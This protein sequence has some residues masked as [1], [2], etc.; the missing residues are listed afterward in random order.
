MS[1]QLDIYSHEGERFFVADQVMG[2]L[3]FSAAHFADVLKLVSIPNKVSFLNFQGERRPE[4]RWTASLVSEGGVREL[5]ARAKGASSG[6]LAEFGK[7]GFQ[8]PEK[9]R[10]LQ[11]CLEERPRQLTRYFQPQE[12]DGS[13]DEA[14]FVGYEIT[15]LLGYKYPARALK[16]QVDRDNRMLFKDFKGEKVPSIPG[17]TVLI[18]RKGACQLLVTTRQIVTR[19]AELIFQECGIEC[20]NKKSLT[21]EQQTISPIMEILKI[22][23]PEF[24]Y[25]VGSYRLDVYF[26]EYK[27]VVECDEHGHS[28]RHP[29]LELRREAFVNEKLDLSTDNWVRYN[30]DARDFDVKRV[31]RMITAKIDR[32]K[33]S[34]HQAESE[35]KEARHQAELAELKLATAN[36]DPE[37]ARLKAERIRLGV[38]LPAYVP[39]TKAK[40]NLH[41]APQKPCTRCGR[42]KRL[43]LF[44][45]AKSHRDGR[46]NMC[47]TCKRERQQEVLAEQRKTPFASEKEC[48]LCYATKS[49]GEFYKDRNAPDGT[50]RRCKEC[51]NERQKAPPKNRVLISEKRCTRCKEVKSVANFHKLNSSRDGYKIYCKGCDKEMCRLRKLP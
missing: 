15:T 50:M 51:H 11:E 30:P 40:K 31:I 48:N 1:D 18:N 26:P 5:L 29:E 7:L 45:K 6:A 25:P 36:S 49:L 3:G 9:V 8:L 16:T 47:K 14:Y 4:Q 33:E 19:D 46:E 10:T 22:Y 37:V 41:L 44:N 27:I 35:A 32:I 34:R 12:L 39:P 21:K 13:E 24:Q 38:G 2:K 43:E 23:K 42:V 28:D 17:R 20:L